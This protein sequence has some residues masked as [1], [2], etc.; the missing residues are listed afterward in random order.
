MIK[1]NQGHKVLCRRNDTCGIWAVQGNG[2]TITAVGI[3]PVTC[4]GAA[5]WTH[6]L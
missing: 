6:R 5:V 3:M 2:S 1:I 4:T